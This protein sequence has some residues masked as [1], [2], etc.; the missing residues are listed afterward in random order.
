MMVVLVFLLVLVPLAH[1]LAAPQ[2]EVGPQLT[3]LLAVLEAL[4][5]LLAVALALLVV[6]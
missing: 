4:F 2:Q 3:R 1:Q 5:L 6:L